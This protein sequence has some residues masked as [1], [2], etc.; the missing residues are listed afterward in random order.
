MDYICEAIKVFGYLNSHFLYVDN[1][2]LL[3]K[4]QKQRRYLYKTKKLQYT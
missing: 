4:T 2:L 3:L 1:I